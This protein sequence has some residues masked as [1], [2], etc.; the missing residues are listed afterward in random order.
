MAENGMDTFCI[1]SHQISSDGPPMI[2]AEVGFNHN[3]E[4]GLAEQMTIAAAECGCSAVKFQAFHGP[5]LFSPVFEAEREDGSRWRPAEFYSQ[6]ELR[7]EEY[8]RLAKLAAQ[9]NICFLCT[10]FDV[11]AAEMLNGLDMAAYKIASGDLTHEVLIRRCAAMGRPM[12]ISTGMGRLADVESAIEFC[13]A[14][15]NDR[16]V[17]LH[18]TSS[19]PCRPEDI[20][21]KAMVLLRDTFGTPVGLSDHSLGSTAAIGATAL[22]AVMIEKH[23]TTDR[24]LPGFDQEMSADPEGMRSLVEGC[25]SVHEAM[26][27]ARKAPLASESGMLHFGVRSLVYTRD[28]PAGSVLSEAN[29]GAKR[30]SIGIPA[31]YRSLVLGRTLTRDV[32]SETF[33]KWEELGEGEHACD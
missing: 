4:I 17:L 29:L 18:C 10:P 25:R 2:I 22:G 20:H 3:A 28:L 11:P 8:K 14:E 19:Y 33:V 30:P 31:K 23:F 7:D 12:I 21:L 13:R 5:E 27:Q 9:Q 26:G 32:K 1:G 15:G 6:Y 24:S 16:I